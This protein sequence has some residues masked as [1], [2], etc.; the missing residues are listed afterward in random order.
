MVLDDE[1]LRDMLLQR[2]TTIIQDYENLRLHRDKLRKAYLKRFPALTP[3]QAESVLQGLGGAIPLEPY[4]DA[5][6][7]QKSFR[8]VDDMR[9]WAADTQ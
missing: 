2:R 7:S 5:I 3:L 6:P 8:D 1:G 4:H 9:V